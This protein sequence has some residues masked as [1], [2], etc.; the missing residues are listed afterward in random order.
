[1]NVLRR[2]FSRLAESDED[3]L[4]EEV[5]EWA[6]S[7]SDTTR[8][9]ETPN[10]QRVKVAGIVRRITVWPR[11][12]DEA[13]YLEALLSDGTGDINLQWT[14]R[15]SIPGLTLGSRLVVEGV[16]RD[17]RDRAMRTMINP[18]FEFV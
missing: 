3:R 14:G 18:K 1:M 6:S 10:R 12:G 8:I 15:R 4:A 11:E 5:R 17:E 9:G 7:V 2:F 13:E 16:V